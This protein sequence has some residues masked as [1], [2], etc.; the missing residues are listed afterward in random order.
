MGSCDGEAQSALPSP[1]YHQCDCQ[2][3]TKDCSLIT[4]LHSS[5]FVL[6]FLAPVQHIQLDIGYLNLQESD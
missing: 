6:L 1:P 4:F 5:D 2:T 3:R